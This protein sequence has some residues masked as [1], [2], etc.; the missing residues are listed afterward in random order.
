MTVFSLASEQPLPMR[1]VPLSVVARPTER[2]ER[3][4]VGRVGRRRPA[5]GLSEAQA[6]PGHQQILPKRLFRPQTS[7]PPCLQQ[8]QSVP[9]G[10]CSS[11]TLGV[12]LTQVGPMPRVTVRKGP[13]L[14]APEPEAERSRKRQKHLH[15]F[16]GGTRG[17]GRD[18]G[19]LRRQ[20]PPTVNINSAIRINPEGETAGT[21]TS[22]AA[23]K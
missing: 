7:S 9:P 13:P 17:R 4:T 5:D 22:R 8:N 21:A 16:G 18:M 2:S 19:F 1:L 23:R 3:A 14:P 20:S 12:G 10:P 11:V 6:S 15:E